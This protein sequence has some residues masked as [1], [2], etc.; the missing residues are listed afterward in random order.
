[1]EC[2]HSDV[3]STALTTDPVTSSSTERPTNVVPTT[4]TT[5]VPT[6][7]TVNHETDGGLVTTSAPTTSSTTASTSVDDKCIQGRT[8]FD[9]S[10]LSTVATPYI[11]VCVK[12]CLDAEVDGCHG[13]TLEVA[14]KGKDGLCYLKRNTQKAVSRSGFLSV[15]MECVHSDVTSTALTTDPVTSA[16][17]E[18][19]TNVVPTTFTTAVPTT[20]T[21]N[22][23]TDDVVT[24]T[25]STLNDKT[26]A[27]PFPT[28]L[29]PTTFPHP[30]RP[31]TSDSTST[32][33]TTITNTA[34]TAEPSTDKS[35]DGCDECKNCSDECKNCSDN[36]H[37]CHHN[38]ECPEIELVVRDTPKHLELVVKN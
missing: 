26:T 34:S 23:T 9:D 13:V 10:T 11:D 4:L 21:V 29:R 30:V 22:H 3:T 27:A 33:T 15:D 25:R 8:A 28:P 20:T 7:T 1:M 24:V 37:G 31:T 16:S 5:E 18:R 38:C 35:C 6:V 2:V 32:T 14:Q 19:P 17:T 36:C 12:A